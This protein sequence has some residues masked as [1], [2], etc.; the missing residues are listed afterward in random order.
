MFI[1]TIKKAVFP[2]IWFS[3]KIFRNIVLGRIYLILLIIFGICPTSYSQILYEINGTIKSKLGKPIEAATVFI[4]G[5]TKITKTSSNG[6][7]IFKGL[8]PG[9]YEIVV[10]MIGYSSIKT[11]AIINSQ[12]IHINIILSPKTIQLKEVQIGKHSK[13]EQYLKTFFDSFVGLTKNAAYCTII[14][15][16]VI[17]FSTKGN[18][19]NAFSDEFIIINNK[20]LGYKISYLLKD[21]AYDRSSATTIF[22]GECVFENLSGTDSQ[23]RKWIKNRAQAYK[24]SF[25]HYLRSLFKGNTYDEAFLTYIKGNKAGPLRDS[26]IDVTKFVS[27]PSNNFINFQFDSQLKIIYAEQ[28]TAPGIILQDITPFRLS[29]MP[30][31]YATLFVDEAVIDEKG[32]YVNYKSFRLEGMWGL[33]RLGDQL[34]FEYELK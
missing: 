24:G 3:R 32:S 5:S 1:N 17:E 31:S 28:I 30:T 12:S 11:N 4:S 14:N 20:S 19:L 8:L 10:R 2:H 33:F 23:E 21:F 25:M 18:I 9:S 34:P 27:K 7:F 15:P 6:Q 16:D 22:D 26:L 29:N 13:R